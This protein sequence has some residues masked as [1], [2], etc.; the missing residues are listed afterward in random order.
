MKTHRPPLAGLRVCVTRAADRAQEL[1]AQ[2]VDHGATVAELP[3]LRYVELP[4]SDAA[5]E[6]LA[7]ALGR[8]AVVAFTSP[9]A[10]AWGVRV[11]GDCRPQAYAVA[12]ATAAA[13][14]AA[15]FEVVG[16]PDDP[17]ATSLAALIVAS[18]SHRTPIVWLHNADARPV[19]REHLE[20]AGRQV[21]DIATYRSEAEADLVPAVDRLFARAVDALLFTSSHTAEVFDAA[22]SSHA[23][24]FDVPVVSIGTQTSQTLRELG[25]VRIAQAEV[26]TAAAMV[27]AVVDALT[28]AVASGQ[29]AR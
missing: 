29:D 13:A 18:E 23:G 24:R 7:D 14:R 4:V 6:A 1:V 8:D 27:A 10:V 2:L 28:D 15:G 19:L 5:R 12:P 26:P 3:V 17:G 21:V 9:S 20:T 25:Y 11:L 16:M 22:A